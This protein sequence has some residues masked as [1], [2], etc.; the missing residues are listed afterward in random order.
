MVN[1]TEPIGVCFDARTAALI[2]PLTTDSAGISST[3]PWIT[4]LH[5]V[6][7][8]SSSTFAEAESN[9]VRNSRSSAVPAGIR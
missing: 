1:V 8:I 3:P 9:G 2:L 7:S 5:S 4:G 6:A